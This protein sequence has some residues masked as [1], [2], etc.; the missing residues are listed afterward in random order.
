MRL[1]RLC[2]TAK[3]LEGRS[4]EMVF[5][6][7]LLKYATVRLKAA[8]RGVSMPFEPCEETHG[9]PVKNVATEASFPSP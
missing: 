5:W 9:W 1:I 3:G 7:T 8:M 2:S 6:K 4:L